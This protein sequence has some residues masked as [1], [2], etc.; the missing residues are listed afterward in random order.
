MEPR[1]P[2]G[3]KSARASTPARLAADER[4]V[5]SWV[6]RNRLR[7][8]AL[9]GRPTPPPPPAR[10]ERPP[11]REPRVVVLQPTRRGGAR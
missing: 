10:G 5:R 4:P 1:S 11:A 9:L 7:L 8:E 2:L 3:A 6:F